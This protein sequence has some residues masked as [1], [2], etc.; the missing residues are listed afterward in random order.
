VR[1]VQYR[2]TLHELVALDLGLSDLMVITKAPTSVDVPVKVSDSVE[3][4]DWFF[5]EVELLES[6]CRSP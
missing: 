5:L 1:V 3:V 6:R 4:E 2:N